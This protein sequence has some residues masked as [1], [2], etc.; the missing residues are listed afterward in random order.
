M[1]EHPETAEEEEG[2]REE[3]MES[4]YQ[5]R[6]QRRQE[7]ADREARRQ[8]RRDARARGDQATLERLRQESTLRA[9]ERDLSGTAAMIAEHQSKSRERRVGSVSYAELG[10][11]RHD[12]TRIRANRSEEQHV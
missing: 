11:A 9:Q 2:R 5:I 7:I 12:G 3:E 10:V 8:E 1:V 6:L 4:L